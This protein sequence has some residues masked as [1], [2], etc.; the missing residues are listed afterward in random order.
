[1][2]PLGL[3]WR[4][5]GR[6]RKRELTGHKR[7]GLREGGDEAPCG[8]LI[9]HLLSEQLFRA[10]RAGVSGMNLAQRPDK[11]EGRVS[12]PDSRGKFV[13]LCPPR[14][15]FFSCRVFLSF[16]FL[17]VPRLKVRA[18]L[19]LARSLF[20]ERNRNKAPPGSRFRRC[21]RSEIMSLL[22]NRSALA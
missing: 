17:P 18:V 20:N 6:E 16:F 4:I 7:R 19:S 11:S 9:H 5:G 8:V 13:F 1:M 3:G 22:K 14:P 10:D 15:L 2:E 12:I 21:E